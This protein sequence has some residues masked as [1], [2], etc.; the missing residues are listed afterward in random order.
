MDGRTIVTR[1]AIFLVALSLLNLFFGGGGTVGNI[2]GLVIN[3]VLAWFLIAGH[4][5]A[6]IWTAIR[7]ALGAVFTAAAWFQLGSQ[8][9]GL[10]SFVRLWTL[11]FAAAFAAIAAYLLLSKRVSEYFNPSTGF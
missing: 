5:W 3:G 4:S 2:I 7:C 9:F 8:G 6:R 11:G 1:I 10:F